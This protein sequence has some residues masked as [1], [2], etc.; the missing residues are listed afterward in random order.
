MSANCMQSSSNNG[1]HHVHATHSPTSEVQNNE[2]KQASQSER[3]FY[4]GEAWLG[5]LCDVSDLLFTQLHLASSK[6]ASSY[7]LCSVLFNLLLYDASSV[8]SEQSKQD[9]A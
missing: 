2:C 3:T 1:E 7:F 8:W 9:V 6:N 4:E 5:V